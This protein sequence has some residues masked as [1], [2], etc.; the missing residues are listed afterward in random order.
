[1]ASEAFSQDMRVL[2]A[3]LKRW[4][5][6][7]DGDGGV[8]GDR[9]QLCLF[10][11]RGRVKSA[12]NP[13]P[14]P[15][16][17]TGDIV[18]PR[19]PADAPPDAPPGVYRRPTM[20]RPLPEPRVDP[21]PQ[22]DVRYIGEEMLPELSIV[23]SMILHEGHDIHPESLMQIISRMKCLVDFEGNIFEESMSLE[24]IREYRKGMWLWLSLL[25]RVC[26]FR[27]SSSDF[28]LSSSSVSAT[29]AT[30]AQSIPSGIPGLGA[31]AVEF[32]LSVVLSAY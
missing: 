32:D 15:P 2:F 30:V 9:Y 12:P 10:L 8:A 31:R 16:P 24:L 14:P 3:L 29:S 28:L 11:G 13:P 20:V 17:P 6:R 21:P 22:I 19:R 25:G 26:V 7:V 5:E 27:G 23:S 4:E 18:I 1:M